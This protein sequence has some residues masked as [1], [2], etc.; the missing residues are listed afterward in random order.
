[1][2]DTPVV[3]NAIWQ[4]LYTISYDGNGNTGGTTPVSVEGV[5]NEQITIAGSGTLQKAGYLL[6]GWS[7]NQN[8]TNGQYSSGSMF[9]IGTSNVTLYAVWSELFTITFNGNGNTSGTAPQSIQG[10]SGEN[11]M[12]SGAGNLNKTAYNF[13]G[14]NTK[15]DATGIAYF[16]N[17]QIVIENN[18]I[19]LYAIWSEYALSKNDNIITGY[20][21]SSKDIVIPSVINTIPVTSIGDLAFYN[22]QLIS[23][24]IPDSVTSIDNSAFSHNQ[25]TSVVIPNSVVTIGAYAFASNRLTSVVI[26]DSV[27]TIGAF[28]FTSNRLTSVVISN[29]ITIIEGSV[30]FDN[31][32]TSVVIPDSVTIIKDWAFYGNQLTSIIIPDSVVTIGAYAFYN[33]RLTSVVI[34][35][36]VVTIGDLAFY[37]NQ[38]ISVVIPNSVT[39]IGADAFASNQL[40]SLVI[41]ANVYIDD[42]YPTMGDNVYSFITFYDSNGKK[43]GT[44]TYEE[45][46]WSAVFE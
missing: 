40:T 46:T 18:D 4:K 12:V 1:M 3:L 31:R 15:S 34:P 26:P 37:N 33:N 24:V 8:A 21:G 14:W 6:V 43:A 16:N 9:V 30:F 17:D 45:S 2:G 35:N 39:T 36:S 28:A 44:Y 29:S 7:I 20:S 22:N 5:T 13:C 32:L 27:V 25:L 19:I 23:V 41:P 11:I 38:L 42:S 10:I